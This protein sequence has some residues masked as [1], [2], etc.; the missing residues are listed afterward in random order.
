MS[1]SD[2]GLMPVSAAVSP[3]PVADVPEAPL[4]PRW[5]LGYQQSRYSYMTADETRQVA[6]KLRADGGGIGAAAGE[7]SLGRGPVSSSRLRVSAAV[8]RGYVPS[9]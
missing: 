9:I 6:A 7:R 3:S 2:S 4:A 5:A 8:G 1:F